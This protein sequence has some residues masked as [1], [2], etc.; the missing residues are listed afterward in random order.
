MDRF[1]AGVAAFVFLALVSVPASART[2][3]V[4]GELVDHACYMKDK[5]NAGPAHRECADTCARKG[6]PVALVTGEGKVYQ[7]TGSLAADNNAKL[8][9]HMSHTVEITGD[10]IEKDGK[11]TIAAEAGGLKMV[12]R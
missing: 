1:S 10:V 7:I 2:D 9:P 3:T 4:K 11:L 6:Q 8:A 5:K 12:S